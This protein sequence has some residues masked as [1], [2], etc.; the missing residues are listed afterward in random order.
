MHQFFGNKLSFI[1]VL[2][3]SFL[4]A[5]PLLLCCIYFHCSYLYNYY[6][7]LET[8]ALNML[9]FQ[10]FM[11][12]F[13]KTFLLCGPLSKR[14][15]DSEWKEAQRQG[16]YR[17]TLINTLMLWVFGKSPTKIPWIE[18]LHSR[19]IFW[20]FIKTFLYKS[21]LKLFEATFVV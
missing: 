11:P 3:P 7:Y 8:S 10:H 18:W 4:W 20:H 16:E 1:F 17:A 13:K 21:L 14:G 5:P 15:W 9:E 2:T 6:N 19:Q 12:R